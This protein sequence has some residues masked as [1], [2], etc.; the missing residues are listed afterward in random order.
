[1]DLMQATGAHLTTITGQMADNT[2]G[3]HLHKEERALNLQLSK[4]PGA[5]IMKLASSL[6]IGISHQLPAMSRL[7]NRCTFSLPVRI[8]VSFLCHASFLIFESTSLHIVQASAPNRCGSWGAAPPQH[9]SESGGS[10]GSSGGMPFDSPSSEQGP[11]GRRTAPPSEA[12][13]QPVFSCTMY[14]GLNYM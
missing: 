14:V 4:G 5:T 7:S 2:P 8:C 13:S 11:W 10:W 1:M 12:Q 3:Q 9:R 6:A